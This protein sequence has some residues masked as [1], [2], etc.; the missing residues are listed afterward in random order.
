MTGRHQNI[1]HPERVVWTGKNGRKKYKKGNTGGVKE[2]DC[3]KRGNLSP[4]DNTYL[5]LLTARGL[6]KINTPDV[7]LELKE[8]SSLAAG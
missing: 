5:S 6:S 3:R 1:S 2:S 8:I 7:F 4:S